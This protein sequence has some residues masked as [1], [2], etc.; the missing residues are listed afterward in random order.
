M[1]YLGI[2]S[3]IGGGQVLFTL[4]SQFYWRGRSLAAADS[5]HSG[6]LKRLL[7]APMAFFNTTPLGR[8]VNR[9]VGC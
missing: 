3:A 9:W 1:W 4:V 8:I 7:R 2:Y 5:L 6:M